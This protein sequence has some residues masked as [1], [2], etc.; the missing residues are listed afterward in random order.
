LDSQDIVPMSR[1][2]P[3]RRE[4]GIPP[5]K[6]VALYAGTIG[7]VSG[8]GVI[9]EVAKALENYRDIL[10]LLV[11]DGYAKEQVQAESQEQGLTNIMFQP[12]QPR[13][14]LSEL[15]ATADV[16][17]VTLSP[18]RGR[19]SVPSKVL[20]YMAAGRPTVAA[21]D[22]D[23]DTAYMVRIANCGLVVAAGDRDSVV[24]AIL[25]Y[26]NN[27][28]EGKVA[29]QNGRDYFVNNFEKKI[30]I[31]KHFNLIQSLFRS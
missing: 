7:L 12:F 23:C 24:Q 22:L 8:A 11:G 26:Y 27:P 19:T 2:N 16:S 28:L 25:H 14:R 31:K 18:G 9:I 15:Q 4:M 30:I 1:D 13:E 10:F 21:V 20:G 29:G 3:W 5:E 6:F 17:L